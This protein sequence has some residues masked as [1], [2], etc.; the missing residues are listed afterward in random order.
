M[1]D[2]ATDLLT[3]LD[4]VWSWAKNLAAKSFHGAKYNTYSPNGRLAIVEA[5]FCA[6]G[7]TK[8]EGPFTPKPGEYGADAFHV[9]GRTG[10]TLKIGIATWNGRLVVDG[11]NHI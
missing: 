5:M 4:P 1:T 8:V 10:R 2:T 11:V 9:T 6:A 7:A 3:D